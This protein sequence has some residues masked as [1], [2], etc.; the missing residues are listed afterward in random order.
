MKC[1][2]HCMVLL[3]LWPSWIE[4]RSLDSPAHQKARQAMVSYQ[5]RDRGIRDTQVLDAM[6]RVLRHRFVPPKL[7]SHAYAD[8]PLPIGEG[9]TISQPYIVALM[10][11]A[12]KMARQI[13]QR[14]PLA[15]RLSRTAI[16]QGLDAGFDQI[17]EIEANHLLICVGAQNQKQFVEKRLA[18]MKRDDRDSL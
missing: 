18:Q 16:D 1:L 6:T 7:A 11:E 14:S 9:Q 15:L 5:I 3:L 4:A 2:S 8:R 12:L 13:G 10:T 17:L